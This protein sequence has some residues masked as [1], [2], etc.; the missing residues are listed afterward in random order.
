MGSDEGVLSAFVAPKRQILLIPLLPM[1]LQPAFWDGPYKGALAGV[2]EMVWGSMFKTAGRVRV[3]RKL[4][5]GIAAKGVYL[6]CVLLSFRMPSYHMFSKGG[7]LRRECLVVG[8]SRFVQLLAAGTTARA[9][10]EAVGELLLAH[11]AI[12]SDVDCGW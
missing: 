6:V 5:H 9:N 2:V 3:G 7:H 4:A 10:L 8:G 1:A 11:M 12:G